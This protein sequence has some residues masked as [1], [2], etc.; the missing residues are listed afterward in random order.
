VISDQRSV[1]GKENIPAVSVQHPGSQE[2][3]LLFIRLQQDFMLRG[4]SHFE[5]ATLWEWLSIP[6]GRD[7][8]MPLPQT[9]DAGSASG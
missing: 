1:A 2:S 6:S 5:M 9:V 7:G 4:N 8:K 3:M